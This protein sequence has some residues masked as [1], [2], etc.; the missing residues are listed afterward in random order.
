MS[1]TQSQFESELKAKLV[2]R[3]THRL[4]SESV[5]LRAF[6]YFD[7]DNSGTVSYN[8]WVRAVEKIGVTIL[9]PA[10]LKRIFD[11]YDTNRSGSLDYKEFT[12]SLFRQEASRP[13]DQQELDALYAEV[14]SKLSNRGV[15]GL[16]GLIRQFKLMD[17]N[18]S[19]LI[20]PEDFA[21]AIKSYRLNLSD[22][23]IE[24][25]YFSAQDESGLANYEVLIKSI[26][27]A[28]PA[29]RR[30]V[31]EA[32]YSDILA[33]SRGGLTL[34]ALADSFNARDHPDVVTANR[35]DEEAFND[36]IETFEVCYDFIGARADGT[37]TKQHFEEYSAFLSTLYPSD[38]AFIAFMTR[39]WNIKKQE[40]KPAPIPEAIARPRTP[41]RAKVT[42]PDA[43]KVLNFLRSRLTQRG[44]RGLIG[45][46]KQ[47]K[48][49]DRGNV[50]QLT[51][52]E[53]KKACRDFKLDLGDQ[54]MES[55][56]EFVDA[57][58]SGM[59][60]YDEVIKQL[61]YP[62]SQ[63][64]LDLISKAWRRVNP[65]GMDAVS[66]EDIKNAF[67]PKQHPSVKSGLK[68]EDEIL[69]EFLETFESHHWISE[70][71]LK[72]RTVN[73]EEFKEYYWSVSTV[74]SDDAVFEAQIRAAWRIRGESP[75]KSASTWAKVGTRTTAEIR[76]QS[77]TS[78][79][80]NAPF[81]TSSDPIDWTT[82]LR[83]K[84]IDDDL[85]SV[86]KE[87]PCAGI[88]T[89]VT[90][91]HKTRPASRQG[92]PL[93]TLLSNIRARLKNRGVRGFIGLKKLF[94]QIDRDGNG[95]IDAEEFARALRNYR[96]SST[97]AEATQIF[98]YFE[99][100]PGRISYPT[101]CEKLKGNLNDQRR[102]L[103]VA[104]FSQLNM[105]G[106]GL[107]SIDDVK[108]NFDPANH[109]DVRMGKKS[110]DEV[111]FEF[112]DSFQLHHDQVNPGPT[113]DLKEFIQY[114]HN[115]S[116][117]VDDDRY[118]ELMLR[119]T[120]NFENKYYEKA[121]SMEFP[122]TNRRPSSRFA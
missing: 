108:R 96:I 109:P 38:E 54:D 67:S 65:R 53:F 102:G 121:W 75:E 79:H 85:L 114:Y 55:I 74:V 94:Q 19:R 56:F 30:Q 48:I 49:A 34:Q 112:L 20:E 26:R 39:V 21:A 28:I 14:K 71:S 24:R 82:S 110:S 27:G 62:L 68:M 99:S 42:K 52:A 63:E 12:A 16:V 91:A 64:R 5:L 73:W 23:A 107:A 86:S 2:Q 41:V 17:L 106:D 45:L 6:K 97:D 60:S 111:L 118:F 115:V 47:F 81:G 18:G 50:R 15:R 93:D 69:G 113:V 77:G 33:R 25:L 122:P 76:G 105:A 90:D 31:I 32:A 120:W 95:S 46:Q 59:M 89:M 70:V 78:V 57:D 1:A 58:R 11:A 80:S 40:V 10:D 72:N 103:I 116:A 4:T 92:Y 117:A 87:I 61:R 101:F 36:F 22:E 66:I 84:I 37:V 119:N 44:I 98:A 100:S 104:A 8:E 35:T 51:I 13:R 83:P 43:I 29:S 3:T 7:L 9:N 88:A